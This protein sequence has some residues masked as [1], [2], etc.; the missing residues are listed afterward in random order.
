MSVQESDDALY[1]RV[2]VYRL[3]TLPER[4]FRSYSVD[5]V[6]CP[7]SPGGLHCPTCLD[8]LAKPV[9]LGLHHRNFYQ[10]FLRWTHPFYRSGIATFRRTDETQLRVSVCVAN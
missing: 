7:F 6:A 3:Q 4:R 1:P 2:S 9:V 8:D 10:D 5:H